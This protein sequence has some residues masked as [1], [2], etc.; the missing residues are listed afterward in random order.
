MMKI[1]AVPTHGFPAHILAF[2]HEAKELPGLITTEEL[3]VQK[4]SHPIHLVSVAEIKSDLDVFVGVL[5]HDD[6]IVV[7]VCALPFA[8]EED[9]ATGLHFGCSKLCRLKK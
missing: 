7:D 6:T 1:N 3:R 9:C 5:N 2:V 4:L 8:L